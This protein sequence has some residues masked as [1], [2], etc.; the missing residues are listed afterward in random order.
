MTPLVLLLLA[1]SPSLVSVTG[2]LDSRTTAAETLGDG[3]AGLNE[4][5]E[6]NVQLKLTPHERFTVQADASLFWQ[7]AW[8]LHGGDRDL[9]Q[10]RPMVVLSEAY[11]DASPQ[12]SVRL[13]AG[14][15][16]I[17]WGSGLAFNP[18][19]LL[20]PPKD[21]TN[22]TFQRAGAW[23][24]MLE[25]PFEKV[26]LS[27]V[28]SGKTMQQYAG[29]PTALVWYPPSPSFEAT[30]GWVPDVRDDEAHWAFM[31]RLYLL[32]AD[33][34]VT[35]SLAYTN[36]YND[37]FQ[38]KTRPGLSL[39]RTFGGLEV[40]GEALWQAGSS[41]VEVTDGCEV[42]PVQ[43]FLRGV[44]LASRPFLEADWLNVNAVVGGRYYFEDGGIFS[45]EYFYNGDGHDPAGFQRLGTLFKQYPA[46][47]QAA[48][49]Q[50]QDP[51]TP[52]QFAFVPLRR[53]YLLLSY[54]KPQLFD[55]WTVFAS[56]LASLEDLSMQLVPQV[57][58]EP[59]QWLR[60]TLAAYIPLPGVPEWGVTIGE[61]SY[62][63]FT[64]SAYGT[65][66]LFTARAF[67]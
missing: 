2:Y 57:S 55:D 14:K 3:A 40:H 62:G 45:T 42:S 26:A 46:L 47:V 17:V 65:R 11:V 63:E 33:T 27:A 31:S 7:G 43:C 60:L 53:H 9:P 48:L 1:Q 58:Y 51:G 64:L 18:T 15:K 25:F 24:G 34:D 35:V 52:Q 16:R 19:D 28:V 38:N 23:L 5:V 41:R 21:P 39:S 54:Q 29:L 4:L 8:F 20:N 50:S 66:V 56:V 13:L 59:W 61:D 30:L 37:A 32:V 22:P 44:P 67:F 49:G 36:L 12:E 10:Y 6:G